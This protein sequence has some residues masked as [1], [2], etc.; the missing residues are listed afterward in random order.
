M[1]H[2]SIKFGNHVD[3]LIDFYGN[4]FIKFISEFFPPYLTEEDRLARLSNS[5]E[6]I[7][8]FAKEKSIY[9]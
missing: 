9:A 8:R 2:H 5:L 7:K 3:S 4:F 1:S 6:T